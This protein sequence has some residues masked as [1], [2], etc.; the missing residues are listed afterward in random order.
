VPE[1]TLRD[2]ARWF[3]IVS[4]W[5]VC[6]FI[7]TS[8]DAQGAQSKAAQPLKQDESCLACHGQA[9]MTAPNGKSITI[10]PRKHAVSV[11]G[12][13]ACVD[14]HTTIKDYPHPAKVKQ[15]QCLT[16]HEDEAAHVPISVHGALGEAA[17][18]SC[19]GDAHEVSASAQIAP[20]QCAQCHADEV[21]EFR[22]SIHGQAAAA[23]DPDAPTCMSCHGPVHQIQTSSA[24]FGRY[25]SEEKSAGHLRLLSQQPAVSRAPQNSLRA[26]GRTLQAERARTRRSSMATAPPQL[27]RTATEA[28]EFFPRKTRALR[29]AISIFRPLAG[30]AIPISPKPISRA[31]TGKP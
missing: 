23:G 30:S 9:G 8:V 29:L 12:S 22:Q 17:C 31:C 2:I 21:K 19:H 3:S 10:D 4:P 15:V 11:H 13:L 7:F 27:A 16:C 6:V 14:C 24:D 25:S 28:T 18:V 1:R 26:P 5:L 20:T